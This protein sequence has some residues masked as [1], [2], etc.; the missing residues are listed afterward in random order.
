MMCVVMMSAFSSCKNDD[1]SENLEKTVVGVWVQD[2]DNDILVLTQDGRGSWYDGINE[3]KN[4][5]VYESFTWHVSDEWLYFSENRKM[6]PI[7]ISKNKIVWKEY[8]EWIDDNDSDGYDSFGY[9]VI[10]TWERI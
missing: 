3:Y 1:S 9:Y 8:D 2:G 7:S 6:R 5:E 4:N 10:W